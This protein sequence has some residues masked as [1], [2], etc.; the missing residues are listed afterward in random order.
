MTDLVAQASTSNGLGYTSGS[1]SAEPTAAG[2]AIPSSSVGKG[3]KKDD[4]VEIRIEFGY[5]TF[6]TTDWI[7]LD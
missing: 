4:E 2:A 7:G 6:I 3:P 1:S 5:V